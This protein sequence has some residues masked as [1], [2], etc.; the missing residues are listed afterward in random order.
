MII[1][2]LDVRIGT[3]LFLLRFECICTTCA[4]EHYVISSGNKVTTLLPPP[5][6]SEGACTP[7]TH[8][9]IQNNPY[10]SSDT[11]IRIELCSGYLYDRDDANDK[12]YD[13]WKLPETTHMT[14][15]TMWKPG[16]TCNW[17]PLCRRDRTQIHRGDRVAAVVWVV[18][19]NPMS[20][21]IVVIPVGRQVRQRRLYGNLALYKQVK[22]AREDYM[23]TRLSAGF[24]FTHGKTR[25]FH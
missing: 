9:I 24:F 3:F 22:T 10:E 17:R 18:L 13:K 19:D 14:E 16:L 7:I 23:Q 4:F 11:V 1:V 12:L 15:T 8:A 2:S 25:R 6:K 5:P 20:V 21:F